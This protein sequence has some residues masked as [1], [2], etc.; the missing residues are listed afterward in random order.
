MQLEMKRYYIIFFILYIYVL[1]IYLIPAKLNLEIIRLKFVGPIVWTSL[2]ILYYLL[3]IFFVIILI[4]DILKKR[5]SVAIRNL[6]IVLVLFLFSVV[7]KNNISTQH[8]KINKT[9][10]PAAPPRKSEY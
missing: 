4:V 9:E 6:L 1:V 2:I 8:Q 5:Y 7:V 3:P 10:T